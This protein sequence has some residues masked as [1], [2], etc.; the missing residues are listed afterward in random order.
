MRFSSGNGGVFTIPRNVNNVYT[1][2]VEFNEK[3]RGR[4]APFILHSVKA[5]FPRKTALEPSSS[6]ILRS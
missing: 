6:S 4:D 2:I 5:F 1:A 3:E